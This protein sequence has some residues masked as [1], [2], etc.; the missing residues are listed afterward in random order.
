MFIVARDM[1]GT[2]LEGTDGRVGALYDILF[3]DQSWKVRHLV[4]SSDRWFEGRQVLLEPDVVERPDWPGRHVQVRLSKEEVRYCPSVETDLPV[5]RREPQEPSQVLVSEAYW[6]GALG[7]A[8]A[9]E[10]NPH[11]RSVRLL[12]GVHIHCPDGRLGHVE[13]FI[14]DDET[15]SVR[16]LVVDTRNWWPGKRVLIEPTSVVSIHW[17]EREI[18]LMLSRD[19]I[20]QRPAFDGVVPSDEPVVGTA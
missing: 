7:A 4:V 13:D 19:Q 8:T 14:I 2:P 12:T 16:G 6:G 10:G 17:P 18:H 1:L 11:L 9:A 15:W 20:E 3:D 5:A